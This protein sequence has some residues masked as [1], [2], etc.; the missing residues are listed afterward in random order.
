MAAF[1]FVIKTK[2]LFLQ[3]NN[4]IM[5]NLRESSSRATST[6]K[7]AYRHENRP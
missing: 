3:K 7:Q 4:A 1:L 2:L 5:T 6:R